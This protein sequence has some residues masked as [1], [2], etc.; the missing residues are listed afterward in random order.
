M[1][2]QNSH[3]KSTKRRRIMDEINIIN[4]SLV[5]VSPSKVLNIT[6]SSTRTVNYIQPEPSTSSITNSLPVVN[7]NNPSSDVEANDICE[8]LRPESTD[9]ES[10]HDSC[11]R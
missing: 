11:L 7:L 9:T 8:F 4:H 1:F 3:S 6:T 10:D 5:Y 2:R